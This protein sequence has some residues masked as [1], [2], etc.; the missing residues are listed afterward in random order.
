MNKAK[1]LVSNIDLPNSEQNCKATQFIKGFKSVMDITGGESG[2]VME[3]VTGW[4]TACD[5]CFIYDNGDKAPDIVMTFKDGTVAMIS[6]D[7]VVATD[8]NI[9]ARFFMD[10]D[11][12]KAILRKWDD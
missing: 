1:I 10:N 6:E 9:M 4:G 8:V 12:A 11:G 2:G 7:Q 5:V 3:Y